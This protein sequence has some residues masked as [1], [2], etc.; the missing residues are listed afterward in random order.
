MIF[1]PDMRDDFQMTCEGLGQWQG[2]ATWLMYFRHRDD[3]PSRYGQFTSNNQPYA[4]KLKGRAWISADNFEIVR[5]E[6]ELSGPVGQLSVQHQ[7]VEYGPVHFKKEN[8]DLWL[9]KTVDLYL[10]INRRQ[11]YRRHSFDRYVLFS[12]NTEEELH[13]PKAEPDNTLVPDHDHCRD[14]SPSSCPNS[15]I[16]EKTPG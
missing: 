16:P 2:Q 1:H 11:Y 8:A 6:S 14:S 13:S 12:V 3:K 10:E 9:P 7:V 15:A 4:V 5:M